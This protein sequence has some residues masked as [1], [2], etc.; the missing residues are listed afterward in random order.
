VDCQPEAGSLQASAHGAACEEPM[1]DLI[2]DRQ[3]LA[4]VVPR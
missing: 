1:I 2:T 4:R 3:K